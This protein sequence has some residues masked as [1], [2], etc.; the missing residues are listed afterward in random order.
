MFQKLE[1]SNCYKIQKNSKNI[2]LFPNLNPKPGKKSGTK[3]PVVCGKIYSN[4]WNKTHQV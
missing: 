2:F 4:N 3:V 1:N